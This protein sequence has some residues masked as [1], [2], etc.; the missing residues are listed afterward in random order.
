MTWPPIFSRASKRGEDETADTAPAGDTAA[1]TLPENVDPDSVT[2]KFSQSETSISA[3][4][5]NTVT[6]DNDSA[7]GNGEAGLEDEP[8]LEENPAPNQAQ[9]VSLTQLLEEARALTAGQAAEQSEEAPAASDGTEAAAREEGAQASDLP[10]ETPIAGILVDDQD[11]QAPPHDP[12]K[13]QITVWMAQLEA[14]RGTPALRDVRVITQDALDL[15][16]AHPGGL[17]QLYAGRPTR[18]SSLVREQDA[19]VTAR[20]QARKL[21]SDTRATVGRFGFSGTYVGIGVASWTQMPPPRNPQ[22]NFF[23]LNV[24]EHRRPEVY[25]CPVLLRPLNL[26]TD[27]SGDIIL[28]MESALVINPV[29]IDTFYRRG[30]SVDT[31]GIA[32]SCLLPS[33]FS[34]TPALSMLRQ[35]GSE[36]LP[37]FDLHETIVAGVL[38]HPAQALAEDMRHIAAKACEHTIVRAL[39]GDQKAR[40]ELKRCVPAPNREDRDPSVERG[41]GDLDPSQLDV[42]EAVAVGASILV[43]APPASEATA[44]VSAI[45]ADGAASGR[46]VF[47]V[48]GVRRIGRNVVAELTKAGL[49]SITTD[50]ADGG[51]WREVLGPSIR[52]AMNPEVT[53]ISEGDL[54]ENRR[55]LVETREKLLSYTQR[56]HVCREPWGVSAYDALQALADLTSAKPGPRTHVRLDAHG[57]ATT[58]TDGL[59][60][61]KQLL[62]HAQDLGVLRAGHT[63][64]AWR[65]AVVSTVEQAQAT[66]EKVKRLA[67]DTLP[68]LRADL[69]EVADET[70]LVPPTTLESWY[71]QL[72]MIDG[73]RQVLDTFQPTVFEKSAADMV[74]ATASKEWRRERSIPMSFGDRRQLVK[75]AKSF[76]RPGTHVDDLHKAL[77][78][79]QTHRDVWRRHAQPGAWPRIPDRLADIRET[80]KQV[81]E[82]IDALTPILATA[83]KDMELMALKDLDALMSNLAQQDADALKLPEELGLLKDIHDMGLDALV[84][85]LRA[86]DVPADLIAAEVDLAWWATILS[87]IL[88]TDPA[89][90]GY[91][92]QALRQ[93]ASSMRQ[94]DTAQVDSLPLPVLHSVTQRVRSALDS[95]PAA[96]Q[97][98][99]E[100]MSTSSA[101]DVST[102][103]SAYP[104]ALALRPIWVL[105]PALVPQLLTPDAPIDLLVLDRVDQLATAELVPL[106]ARA[107]QVVI[108]GDSKRGGEG[109]SLL[110]SRALPSITLPTD[111]A[112]MNEQV[113]VFL[114]AHGYAEDICVVPSPRPANLV[115]LTT[116]DGRATPGP[117]AENV[118]PAAQE[119]AAVVDLVIH[120]AV[121]RPDDSL[122]VIVLNPRMARRV[123]EGVSQQLRAHPIASDFF[124]PTTSTHAEPFIVVDSANALGLRRDVVIVALGYPK[125][126]HGR[127]IHDFGAISSDVGTAHLVDTLEVSRHELHV[128]ASFTPGDLDP[129]RLNQPGARMLADLLTQAAN[130]VGMTRALATPSSFESEPDRLLVDLAERLWRKGLTVVPRFGLPGGVTVP[131]AIGHADLPAE[132]LVAVLTDDDAYVSE[133]SLRRRERYWPQRLQQ[134]GWTVVMLYST[135]VFADPQAKADMVAA[136]VLDALEARQGQIE[137]IATAASKIAPP[138]PDLDVEPPSFEEPRDNSIISEGDKAA[139]AE[140]VLGVAPNGEAPAVPVPSLPRGPRPP[141]AHGLPLAAYGD[142]QLDELLEWICSDG[143]ERTEAAQVEEL[144][145]ALSLRRRGAQVDAVLAHVVRRRTQAMR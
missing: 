24:E 84:D 35:V 80:T 135:E 98:V 51:N 139:G 12:V 64:S 119:V 130:P 106:I 56:L 42:V 111:R 74:I 122:A 145:S 117:N 95:D 67:T 103:L 26:M 143:L 120:H 86:R 4:P 76:V 101:T 3:T 85:D 82:D 44:T 27:Q 63:S 41:V 68:K 104:M 137:R 99:F 136:A 70:G 105:P 29:L 128:V 46:T 114:A 123:R 6:P 19:A 57:G 30:L 83:A 39:A 140:D 96:A 81:Q 14:L 118:E 112:R 133:P 18:L 108:V 141:V 88:T 62:K 75:K 33:G 107:Q 110:A 58:T 28:T 78:Q 9:D 79:V 65:G 53:Q 13:D 11:S 87:E 72:E 132:L 43:E 129:D 113:S 115:R 102:V 144:R 100:A 92:G 25:H 37:G 48:P 61:A 121:T 47:Y 1:S 50:I 49:A 134:R 32:R 54:Q 38:M 7:L 59:K 69:S 93:L 20:R 36:H 89:L 94:L 73:V 52:Q 71:E 109:L 10:S 91:D 5:A 60:Q 2:P 131:L 15:T 40:E 124:D 34:P 22:D 55:A 116:V 77:Q 16:T 45:L 90:A 21:I 66:I 23:D 127:V 31:A 97:V 17:A 138:S 125:T 8:V 126:P 142:D